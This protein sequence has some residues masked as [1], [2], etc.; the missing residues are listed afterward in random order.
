MVEV[1]LPQGGIYC[2]LFVFLLI[3]WMAGFNTSIPLLFPFFWG[4][5]DMVLAIVL[6]FYGHDFTKIL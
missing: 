5:I 6:S 1:F 3:M 2:L 4:F